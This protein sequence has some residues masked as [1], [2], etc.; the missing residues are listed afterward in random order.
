MNN[1]MLI[2]GEWTGANNGGTWDLINPAS[3]EVISTVPFGDGT[4]CQ[5]AIEAAQAAF[6]P[7]SALT[8]FQRATYLKRAADIMRSRIKDLAVTTVRESGKP[9]VEARGEWYVA[10]DFFEWYAEEGKRAYGYTIPSSRSSKRMSVI[11]QP[12]GVV[13]LITAWNFPAYNP[14]R[15]LAAALGA[16]CTAVVKPSEYTPL[17]AIAMVEALQEAGLPA[18]VVNLVNGDAAAI[19]EMMLGHPA[20]RKIHFTGSTRVGRILMDGASRTFTRLSLEM[21]GNAPILVFPDVDIE[22]LAETAVVTKCR[23]GGQVCIS[24][25]RFFVHRSVQDQ[26]AELVAKKAKA[27]KIGDGLDPETNVG[28]LINARQRERVISLVDD[29]RRHDGE[30]LAG[31]RIP[32]G[33]ERGYFYEPTV[34]A[35]LDHQ[36]AILHEEIFGP[37]MPIAPFTEVEEAIAYANETPYGLAA[38]LWTNDLKTAIHVS[39]RL[40]FGMIG[41]NEWAPHA[42][43]APFIGWK[44]S[45][46]GHES[47]REGLKEYMEMKLIS[48]GG[49]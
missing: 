35:G 20:C 25:Q 19:G 22:A 5:A 4:D 18:G 47:G 14:A 16:G 29:A 42:T 46:L 26:F 27:L 36:A 17:T 33:R 10:A 3:E 49:L 38:Y 30:V 12:V 48:I 41:V 31:G 34:V 40:E 6:G 7:W 45:G 8:P 13:G 43:E 39:E 1:K 23:N 28:P 32:E 11:Y 2:N 15:A 21:G 37:V 44:A 24:P 9:F